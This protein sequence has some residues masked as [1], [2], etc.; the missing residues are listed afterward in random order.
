MVIATKMV[1]GVMLGDV[2][3]LMLGV[4]DIQKGLNLLEIR[5]LQILHVRSCR[6]ISNLP[7]YNGRKV[8]L[9]KISV[10]LTHYYIIIL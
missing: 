4:K 2:L 3:P 7:M 10:E 9:S 8:K 6:I 5:L 1:L